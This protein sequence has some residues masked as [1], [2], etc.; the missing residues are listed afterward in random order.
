MNKQQLIENKVRKIVRK[1]LSE[2]INPNEQILIGFSYK[3]LIDE[4]KNANMEVNEKTVRRMF[5]K[6]STQL[7]QDAKVDLNKNI[8]QIVGLGTKL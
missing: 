8:S 6:I 4:V 7:I 5:D 3:D 2:G 1:V